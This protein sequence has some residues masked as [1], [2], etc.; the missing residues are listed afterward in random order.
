MSGMVSVKEAITD[1]IRLETRCLNEADLDTWAIPVYARR[2][3][4]DAP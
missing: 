3:L 4:L 2:L 1:L